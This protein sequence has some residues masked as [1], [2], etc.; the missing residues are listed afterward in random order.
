MIGL[1][2]GGFVLIVL[3][4]VVSLVFFIHDNNV[5]LEIVNNAIETEIKDF[6]TSKNDI[7]YLFKM[8][9]SQKSV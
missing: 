3:T 7:D 2:I 4:L 5:R 1:V 8:E 9:T 6:L